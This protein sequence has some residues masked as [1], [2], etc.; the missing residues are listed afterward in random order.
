M[1]TPARCRS[2]RPGVRVPRVYSA[3]IVAVL[4]FLFT[5]WLNSGDFVGKFEN[6]LLFI[7]YWI[8]P[9]AA[10]VLA[11]WWLRGAAM[12]TSAG[13]SNFA[14]LPSGLLGARRAAHRVHRVAAVPDVGRSAAT[15]RRA[16]ACRSTRSRPTSL[17]YAD[18]A[19]LVGFAVAFVVYWVAGRGAAR[20]A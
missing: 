10:V 12:P 11:D 20:T 19:Y 2:R 14:A 9:W 13:S 3:I 1:T 18:F 15:S 17:H 4:G 8:A 6:Y 5:L 7:S 16:P